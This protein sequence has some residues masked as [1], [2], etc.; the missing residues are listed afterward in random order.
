MRTKRESSRV[1]MCWGQKRGNYIKQQYL[2]RFVE[3]ETRGNEMVWAG[4]VQVCELWNVCL[5]HI[6]V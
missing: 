3:L 5:A 1:C 2:L 4:F 6:C